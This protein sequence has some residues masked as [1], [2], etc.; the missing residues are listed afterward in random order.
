LIKYKL[1]KLI[2][3][4]LL[5]SVVGIVLPVSES[6]IVVN[7]TNLAPSYPGEIP[8]TNERIG[9][10][11]TYFSNTKIELFI[12]GHAATTGDNSEIHL[13][14]EGVKVADTSGKPLGIA[15]ESNKTIIATIPRHVNYSVV[16][17]NVHHYEW[18]EYP[19]E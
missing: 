3:L 9:N 19:Y 8:G 17:A 18:R 1:D 7:N 11:T 5:L 16:V 6:D 2:I 14:I 13:F 10:N 4:A 15:E 12:W